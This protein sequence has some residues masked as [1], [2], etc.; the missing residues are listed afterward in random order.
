[1]HSNVMKIAGALAMAC[2]LLELYL[3]ASGHGRIQHAAGGLYYI[4]PLVMAGAG[5]AIMSGRLALGTGCLLISLGIQHHFVEMTPIY[6]PVF[7]LG[8]AGLILGVVAMEQQDK[9]NAA[10]AE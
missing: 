4:V 9:A 2:G 10:A 5:V 3:V 8:I 6:Y 7:A 1:M